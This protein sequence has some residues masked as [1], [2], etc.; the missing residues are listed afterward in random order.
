MSAQRYDQ[1]LSAMGPV[2]VYEPRIEALQMREHRDRD[3]LVR[4]GKKPVL[5]VRQ[6]SEVPA[7][8]WTS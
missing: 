1:E 5:K 6:T 8:C 3:Q 2:K 4:L 7:S